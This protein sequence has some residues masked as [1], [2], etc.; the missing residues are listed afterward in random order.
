M[1]YKQNPFTISLMLFHLLVI[2]LFGY[3]SNGISQVIINPYNSAYNMHTERMHQTINHILAQNNRTLQALGRVNLTKKSAKRLGDKSNSKHTSQQPYRSN[4]VD[5]NYVPYSQSTSFNPIDNALIPQMLAA[6]TKDKAQTEEMK[7]VQ[8]MLAQSLQFYNESLERNDHKP[9][10]VA[11]AAAFFIVHNVMVYRGDKERITMTMFNAVHK[12]ICDSLTQDSSFRKQT[13]QE[14]QLT[15]EMFAVMGGLVRREYS[16]AVG[17][18]NQETMKMYQELA[19]TNIES[20]FKVPA[21]KVMLSN[22]GL[23]IEP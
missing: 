2:L 15:Y 3:K 23:I 8:D 4:R 19:K 20:I 1:R 9:Y 6:I 5:S 13:N 14:K 18:K 17:Y 12:Q 10:D 21:D 7:T 22:E 11:N 16:I